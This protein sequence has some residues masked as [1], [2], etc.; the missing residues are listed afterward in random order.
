MCAVVYQRILLGLLLTFLMFQTASA[1]N[2]FTVPTQVTVRMYVLDRDSGA[3]IQPERLCDKNDSE[4]S[5]LYGCT[6]F[7]GNDNYAY[8]FDTSSPQIVIDGPVIV[9]TNNNGDYSD[10]AVNAYTPQQ[11]YLWDVVAQE[12]GL[13]LGSQGNKPLAGVAAQTIATRTYLY[14]RI[15]DAQSYAPIDNSAQF[16]VFVPYSYEFLLTQPAQRN[17]LLAAMKDRYYLTPPTNDF[18]IT[19]LYGADNGASTL[20]GATEGTGETLVGNGYN[21]RLRIDDP[22][23]AA[24]GTVDG[25]GYGG[26]SSKGVSRWSFGHTSSRGPAAATDPNYPHDADGYGDFWNVRWEDARQILTH[27]YTNIHIRDANAGNARKTPIYRWAPLQITWST[28][29]GQAP[30]TL[31][32]GTVTPVVAWIQNTGTETW[33][34]GGSITFSYRE[35]PGQQVQ[36]ADVGYAYP[37]QPVAPGATYTATLFYTPASV[38]P[39]DIVAPHFDMFQGA[40]PFRQVEPEQPWPDYVVPITLVTCAPRAYLPVVLAP[41]AVTE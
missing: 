11:R 34:S 7:Q 30:T 38:T 29:D 5:T 3:K 20:A 17:R 10:D 12:Y 41:V 18:P 19:A 32:I 2:S 16:H 1:Q 22:I 26:M 31:C 25:T 4:V 13:H 9:D 15:L 14:Q 6:A 24:Y 39:G 33:A 37:L 28:T 36:A 8:P 23:S 27:Y 35:F 21:P 40:T